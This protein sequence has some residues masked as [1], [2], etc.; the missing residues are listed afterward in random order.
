M[1]WIREIVVSSAAMADL[2]SFVALVAIIVGVVAANWFLF[3]EEVSNPHVWGK[4]ASLFIL[5]FGICL[6]SQVQL[7]PNS[8]FFW[9]GV[10][11]S[12]FYPVFVAA[13][14]ILEW[15]YSRKENWAR[16]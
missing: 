9:A 12:T 5:G 1:F 4:T 10:I 15:C 13:I 2:V 16:T 7:F 6:Y 3:W 8:Y 11:C 14:S